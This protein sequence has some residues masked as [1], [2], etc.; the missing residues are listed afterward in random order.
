MKKQNPTP[1]AAPGLEKYDL[2]QIALLVSKPRPGNQ[3][4]SDLEHPQQ[5]GPL[6]DKYGKRHSEAVFKNWSPAA[7]KALGIRR[8]EPQGGAT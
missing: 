4:Y 1:G 2:P 6:V 5:L 7:I 3:A 8:V